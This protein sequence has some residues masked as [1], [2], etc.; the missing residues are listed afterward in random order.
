MGLSNIFKNVSGV[1]AASNHN[2]SAD[3]MIQHFV[4]RQDTA[5]TGVPTNLAGELGQ[6]NL[7]WAKGWFGPGGVDIDGFLVTKDVFTTSKPPYRIDSG[8]IRDAVSGQPDFIRVN[9]SGLSAQILGA[10]TNLNL[11]INSSSVVVPSDASFAGLTAAPS[12]NNT[13]LVNDV[14]LA[15]QTWTKYVGEQNGS[16]VID[17][18]GSEITNRIGQFA[19]FSNGTEILIAYIKSATELSNCY[20]G[21]FFN[22]S[23]NPIVRNTLSDNGTLT[24]LNLGWVFVENSSTIDV[25]YRTP[26]TSYVQPSAPQNGDYWFDTANTKW[27]RYSSGS[28]TFSVVNRIPVGVIVNSTTACIASR[29]FDFYRVYDEALNFE[30]ILS[31]TTVVTADRAQAEVSVY[32]ITQQIPFNLGKWDITTD[33]E[34]GFSEAASTVYYAY[35]TYRGEVRI[36]PE[37]PQNYS[38][39]R[40]SYH[41]YHAW[42]YVGLFFNDSGSN[43]TYA[44][45]HNSR[46]LKTYKFTTPGANT[47]YLVP[48]GTIIDILSIGGGGGSGGVDYGTTYSNTGGGGGGGS[49]RW[50]LP[51]NF[52][53]YFRSEYAVTVGAGGTAGNNSGSNGGAGGTSSFGVYSSATGGAGS[54]G[55]NNIDAATPGGVGGVGTVAGNVKLGGFP[56]KD[57]TQTSSGDG[58]ASPASATTPGR[59][60]G[61]V[62]TAGA[63]YGGGAAGTFSGGSN[64]V[65]AVGAQGIVLCT[66]LGGNL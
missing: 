23:G 57:A 38:F 29:S 28:G 33:L 20:R 10:T 8:R 24:L 16:I 47:F 25:T 32:G 41:P 52:T 45:S 51:N 49:D 39:R 46:S 44:D 55:V 64:R 58:G 12:T 14:N 40:G 5:G 56:G 34:T 43:I 26:I 21:W 19:A 6:N 22:S 61:G 35:V 9:G 65:G 50:L 54:L 66:V 63:L 15:G 62:G 30:V 27:K 60:T 59:T 36:S 18:V 3:A 42:R 7:R 11:T 4:P 17:T 2:S 53:D 31:S 48:N 13:C 37:R 1:V